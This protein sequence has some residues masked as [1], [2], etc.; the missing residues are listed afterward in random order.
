M[1][2]LLSAFADEYDSTLEGQLKMLSETGIG[3]LEPRF[4]DGKNISDFNEEEAKELKKRL[5]DTGIKVTSIGSP[6]GKIGIYDDFEQHLELTKRVVQTAN[7][8]DTDKIRVF[9]FYHHSEDGNVEKYFDT[10]VEKLSRM[11]EVADGSGVTL[12]HENEARVYGETPECCRQLMDALP[13]LGCV[14]DMGNF[15]LRGYDPLHA[16]RLLKDRIKYFHIK[17]ALSIGA[18]VPP[19]CGEA[20]IADI[21]GDFTKDREVIITLEP[22]LEVFNG[23]KTLVAPNGEKFVNPYRFSSC[24]EAFL[25][26]VKKI[27]EIID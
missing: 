9:S 12:C 22:H 27:R 2:C 4:I 19:G 11:I 8:L 10:T 26:A 16:Y 14:F 21:L 6:L 7:I 25:T 3:Y 15:A 24:E 13:K 17:D 1:K 20:K 23:L 18:I 5:D